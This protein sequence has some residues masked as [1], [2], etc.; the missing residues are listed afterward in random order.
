M[1]SYAQKLAT[2]RALH[3]RDGA[4]LMPNPHDAGT[5]RILEGLG[6]EAMA[7][8]SAGYAWTEGC[9]D[10]QGLITREMA[11]GHARKIAEATSLPVNGDLE[12]GF[13]DAPED[14]A[15]TIRGAIEAGLCGCSIEDLSQAS[16][17]KEYY[18]LDFA[19]ERIKAGIAAKKELAPDFVLAARSEAPIRSGEDL[20]AA[21]ERLN[22]YADAGADLVYAPALVSVDT[23]AEVRRRVPAKLNVLA[24]RPGFKPTFKELSDLGVTRV[25]IGAGLSQ[26]AFAAFYNAAKRLKDDADFSVFSEA[27]NLGEALS[28]MRGRDDD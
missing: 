9:A 14:V 3:E 7:T 4:F 23:I 8:T 13:G 2:F 17:T 25:S 5:A 15:A 24:G 10:V 21:I 1:P 16:G 18:P 12:N 27:Q 19:V 22:A 6:F 26:A 11:L 28:F 20:D